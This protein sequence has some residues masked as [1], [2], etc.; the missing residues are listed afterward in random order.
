M[1]KDT[2]EKG[3]IMIY[4]FRSAK[5]VLKH[6]ELENAEIYF[7]PYDQ[8]NDPME[9]F[10]NL[11]WQGDD[12]AWI[13]LIK[14]YI[15]MMQY[16]LMGVVIGGKYEALKKYSYMRCIDECETD[17][18]KNIVNN[19]I[20]KVINAPEVKKLI[21]SLADNNISVTAM[22][23]TTIM[24]ALHELIIGCLIIEDF[25]KGLISDG[26]YESICKLIP[27]EDKVLTGINS[28]I[29]VIETKNTKALGVGQPIVS[30]LMLIVKMNI[31]D[32]ENKNREIQYLFFDFPNEY[33][34]KVQ[35]LMYPQFYVACF[36][37][38]FENSSMW[39][40]YADE[41]RGICLMFEEKSKEDKKGLPFYLATALVGNTEKYEFVEKKLHKVSYI[42]K[43]AKINFFE[44][45]GILNG[46]QLTSWLVH[47]DKRSKVFDT[48]YN[49]KEKWRKEYWKFFRDEVVN[50]KT[51]DWQ[52]EQEYRAYIDNLFW[53]Y[54]DE[55]KR[56][57]KY[58]FSNLHGIIF[59]IKTPDTDKIKIINIIR[60]K[61]IEEKRSD[62]HFYQA[63][64]DQETGKI[65]Y[66]EMVAINKVVN[67]TEEDNL[68]AKRN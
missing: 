18:L 9:G 49:N 66:H 58:Q 54:D 44:H 50:S 53:N 6:K 43:F 32:M 12:V 7:S 13:G 4:R 15:L 65:S 39:S 1:L 62:F 63:Y 48:T 57:V 24:Q 33:V 67:Y 19:V 31:P 45:L 14:H 38:N 29:P 55:N 68:S 30:E 46:I 42:T 28:L 64:Y 52:H 22:Q 8:L 5:S 11:V 60:K 20:E 10:F 2:E 40:N 59:G 56:K 23:L 16:T 21:T 3:E 17:N 25:N 61:C 35:E 51:L 27:N 36:S 47:N 26:F 41:H 37:K 34:K